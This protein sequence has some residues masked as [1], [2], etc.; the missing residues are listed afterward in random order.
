ML[1]NYQSY[2]F[3]DSSSST[4]ILANISNLQYGSDMNVNGDEGR[5]SKQAF[6]RGGS[7]IVGYRVVGLLV[8][9]GVGDW[10]GDK[11]VG[12]KVGAS[13]GRGDGPYVGMVIHQSGGQ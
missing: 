5:P 3:I 2:P 12:D 4:I 10:V 9:F 8:R 13:V 1:Y 7:G 11:V 6:N